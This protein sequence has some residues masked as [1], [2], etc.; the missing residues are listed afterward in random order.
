[1]RRSLTAL[2]VLASSALIT[3]SLAGTASASAISASP[4]RA[5]SDVPH[6]QVGGGTRLT[7]QGTFSCNDVAPGMTVKVCIEESSDATASTWWSRGCT[8]LSQVEDTNQIVANVFVSVPV[9]ATF[10][11]THVEGVNSLNQKATWNSPPVW[12]FN[13][14][15]YVG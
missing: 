7:S 8:T 10:L 12:W 13:C 14:A 9:Y 15:C 3:V 5:Y 4:C 2:F 1:M 6:L 11:R